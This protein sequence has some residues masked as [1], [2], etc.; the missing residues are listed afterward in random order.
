MAAAPIV[1]AI[2]RN[3]ANKVGVPSDQPVGLTDVSDVQNVVPL[4]RHRVAPTKTVHRRR[5]LR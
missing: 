1:T 5:V 3:L 2:V 4:G